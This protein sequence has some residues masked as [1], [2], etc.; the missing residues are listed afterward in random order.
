MK[1]LLVIAVMV[2]VM[3]LFAGILAMYLMR[4]SGNR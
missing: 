4:L 3:M 2:A 1:G